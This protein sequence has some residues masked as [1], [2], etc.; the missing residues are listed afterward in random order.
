MER[1]LLFAGK[2]GAGHAETVLLSAIAE[3]PT[4]LHKGL[5][6]QFAMLIVRGLTSCVADKRNELL[7]VLRTT[8]ETHYFDLAVSV[9]QCPGDEE[10]VRRKAQVAD[11]LLVVPRATA[12]NDR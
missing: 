4:L 10:V 6:K 1:L 11:A 9:S 12:T 8:L 7:S 5:V 2:C 3:I